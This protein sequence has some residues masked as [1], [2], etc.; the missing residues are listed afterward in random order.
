[1]SKHKKFHSIDAHMIKKGYIRVSVA[2]VA[3]LLSTTHMYRLIKENK[4]DATSIG[5]LKFVLI[6]SVIKY[7]GQDGADLFQKNLRKKLGDQK[8]DTIPEESLEAIL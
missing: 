4:I 3:S 7:L 1:M 8:M 6:P 5:K 2:I